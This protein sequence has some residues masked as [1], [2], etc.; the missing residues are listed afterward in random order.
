ML[1]LLKQNSGM[2]RVHSDFNYVTSCSRAELSVRRV[3]PAQEPGSAVQGSR[4]AAPGVLFRILILT[5]LLVNRR[6][7]KENALTSLPS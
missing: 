2:I 6:L 7:R 5:S 3:K 1:I 4:V